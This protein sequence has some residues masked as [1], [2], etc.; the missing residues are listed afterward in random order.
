MKIRLLFIPILSLAAAA[1]Y[2]QQRDFLSSDE[3]D[4]IRLAQEPSERIELYLKFA[5]KR[6]D[7]VEQLLSKSKPGRSILIH[8]TLDDYSKIIDAIDTVGD[9]ALR[10]KLPIDKG[11][12]AA[13]KAE[14]EFLATLNKI[15]PAAPDDL[16][17]YSFVLQTAIDTTS[18]SLDVSEE[19]VS[20]RSAEVAA[21]D[22]REQ[23]ERESM[24]KSSEVEAKKKAQAAEAEKKK[25]APTLMRPGEKKP[26][27]K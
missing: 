9:D 12:D 2:A 26:D 15:E 1:L 18:D 7:L 20:K 27:E 22:A 21:G 11:M 17:R 23:K 16:S 3:V 25:K 13:V 5:Q 19:N 6:I 4:Q 8:D 14:K 10:R 24:M